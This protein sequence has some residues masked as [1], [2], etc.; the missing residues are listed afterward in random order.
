MF[1]FLLKND[2]LETLHTVASSPIS[3][4]DQID[5]QLPK[6]APSVSIIPLTLCFHSIMLIHAKCLLHGRVIKRKSKVHQCLQG[7]NELIQRTW[8]ALIIREPK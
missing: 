3:H 2:V 5:K 1:Y 6:K 7:L 4:V 8:S